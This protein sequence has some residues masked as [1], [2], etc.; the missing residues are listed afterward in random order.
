[1][2][3]IEKEL[4]QL[5]DDII[6]MMFLVESQL[7]KSKKAFTKLKTGLAKEIH[8][9]EARVNSMAHSINKDCE[10]IIA[11][12]NPVASD[13]RLVLAAIKIV[14]NLERIGDHADNIARYVRKEILVEPYDDEI[15]E[16]VGFD[17]IFSTAL[18][19]VKEAIAG[20]HNEDT[21]IARKVFDKDAAINAIYKK[22][23]PILSEYIQAHPDQTSRMLYLFSIINKLERVGDLA[24]NISEETIFYIEAELKLPSKKKKSS[25]KSSS[26]DDKK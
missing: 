10:N 19:M 1:M 25:S 2:T 20:F 23:A 21:E 4:L 12:Y 5:K 7:Q 13:L 18:E 24:T 3:N 11:L 9:M 16:K 15:L 6:E 8:R 14:I 26:K 17:E 22:S